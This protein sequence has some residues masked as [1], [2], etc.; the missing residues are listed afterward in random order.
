MLEFRPMGNDAERKVVGVFSDSAT[1]PEQREETVLDVFV[2]DL[3]LLGKIANRSGIDAKFSLVETPVINAERL[4]DTLLAG[5]HSIAEVLPPLYYGSRM[6][7]FRDELLTRIIRPEDREFFTM[8]PRDYRVSTE[9]RQKQ[10][11]K[12]GVR[13]LDTYDFYSAIFIPGISVG[14]RIATAI[15]YVSYRFQCLRY[16]NGSVS[17]EEHLISGDFTFNRRRP[18]FD[19]T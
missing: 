11:G 2:R 3:R 6:V 5:S 9:T 12:Q 8:P 17:V 19:T 15:P 18:Y 1:S 7:Q 14:L 4:N 10:L 13:P 16:E